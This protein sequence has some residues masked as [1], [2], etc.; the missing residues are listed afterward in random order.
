MILGCADFGAEVAERYGIINRALPPGEF[1]Y[2]VSSLAQRI[3]G[4]PADAVALAKEAASMSD[5]GI[6]EELAREAAYFLQTLDTPAARRRIAAALAG[7]MQ[8][9]CSNAAASPTSGAPWPAFDQAQRRT[10]G[11]DDEHSNRYSGRCPRPARARACLRIVQHRLLI[12]SDPA[13]NACAGLT[14]LIAPVSLAPVLGPALNASARMLLQ[15]AALT[16]LTFGGVYAL[17]ARHPVRY[18]LYVPLGALLKL[19]VAVTF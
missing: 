16:N 1:D 3:A 19:L 18:R 7:G 9:R 14:F 12:Y 10:R 6:E 11:H 17:I 8:T 13:F 4:F 15:I 5:A 2:F